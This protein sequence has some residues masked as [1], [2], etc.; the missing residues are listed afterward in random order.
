MRRRVCSGLTLAEML[1][2][3]A[4]VAV[5][6]SVLQPA[7]A[8]AML[9]A[10]SA[11]SMGQLHQIHLGIKLYQ[12]DYGNDGMYG[13]KPSQMGL[14][15]MSCQDLWSP[16]GLF[17]PVVPESL[18]SSPCGRQPF[19]GSANEILYPYI[20]GFLMWSRYLEAYEDNALIVADP[21]CN[22]SLPRNPELPGIEKRVIGVTLGGDA[23]AWRT[24]A[25][26]IDWDTGFYGWPLRNRQ[27]LR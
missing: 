12:Q 3:I 20:D 21:N 18:W 15:V 5:L 8:K 2:V 16:K 26:V 6:A 11:K 24:D 4:I 22:E 25:N 17:I 7:L 10:K 14:P 23:H 19:L 9:A 27:Q 1:S 13:G